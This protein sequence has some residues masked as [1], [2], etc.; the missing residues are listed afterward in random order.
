ML[1]E[2]KHFKAVEAQFPLQGARGLTSMVKQIE[3]GA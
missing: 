3:V 1:N 2:E